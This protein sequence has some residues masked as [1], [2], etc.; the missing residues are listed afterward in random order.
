M[1]NVQ[2]TETTARPRKRSLSPICGCNRPHKRAPP[3]QGDLRHCV[4]MVIDALKSQVSGLDQSRPYVRILQAAIEAAE[5]GLRTRLSG[6]ELIQSIVSAIQTGQRD[7][8]DQ[9]VQTLST[10]IIRVLGRRNQAVPSN[11]ILRAAFSTF[12]EYYA[13]PRTARQGVADMVDGLLNAVDTALHQHAPTRANTVATERDMIENI[14]TLLDA[15]DQ[16]NSNIQ[17][18]R[19]IFT[20]IRQYITTTPNWRQDR[21]GNGLIEALLV[22]GNEPNNGPLRGFINGLINIHSQRDQTRQDVSAVRAVLEAARTALQGN[23]DVGDGV[24]D[25]I[26]SAINPEPS[27]PDVVE[28]TRRMIRELINTAAPGASA[29][30]QRTAQSVLRALEDSL[31]RLG[32]VGTNRQSRDRWIIETRR[33]LNSATADYLR[34]ATL[35]HMNVLATETEGHTD[36]GHYGELLRTLVLTIRDDHD[37]N[38][39][40]EA[41]VNGLLAE[42]RHVITRFRGEGSNYF[43]TPITTPTPTPPHHHPPRPLPPP[44]PPPPPPGGGNGDDDSSDSSDSRGPAPDLNEAILRDMDP[45]DRITLLFI[46]PARILG[47]DDLDPEH[48]TCGICWDDFEVGQGI[49]RFACGHIFHQACYTINFLVHHRHLCPFCRSNPFDPPRNPASSSY[50]RPRKHPQINQDTT[51]TPLNPD[52]KSSSQSPYFPEPVLEGLIVGEESA[53]QASPNRR[54]RLVEAYTRQHGVLFRVI[55]YFTNFQPDG[56]L[57]TRINYDNIRFHDIYRPGRVPGPE[58]ETRSQH[59]L[60]LMEM[61]RIENGTTSRNP[62]PPSSSSGGDD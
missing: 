48:E 12:T 61:I 36:A 32:Q 26:L 51:A 25:A 58:A 30:E 1:A 46:L 55:P 44:P 33:L 47:P 21:N 11:Q 13:R 43:P 18:L 9:N 39:D 27:L 54:P 3:D 2:P 22:L 38:L 17:T 62:T 56:N 5:A 19:Q 34:S 23:G 6:G 50:H 35:D 31:P 52:D 20:G 28:F 15:G 29:L 10:N 60:R 7:G 16:T 40:L 24:I 49:F 53:E 4:Q 42:I 45:A 8:T 57:T 14:L 37:I 41:T 59:I